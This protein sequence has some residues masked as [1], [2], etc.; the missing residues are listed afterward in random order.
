MDKAFGKDEAI[1][2]AH[3]AN[4]GSVSTE[5]PKVRRDMP[6]AN[7]S[8]PRTKLIDALGGEGGRPSDRPT[9]IAPKQSIITGRDRTGRDRTG[10]DQDIQ[11]TIDSSEL[12]ARSGLPYSS[13]RT[14]RSASKKEDP[15]RYAIPSQT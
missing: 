15:L 13:T 10:V 14:T 12:R 2:S 5:M 4:K 11:D 8:R 6:L 3:S 9:R 7:E 1:P